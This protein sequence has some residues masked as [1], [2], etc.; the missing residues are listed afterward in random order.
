MAGKGLEDERLTAEREAGPVA[1]AGLEWT[2]EQGA[3]L[4]ACRATRGLSREGLA[5]HFSVGART[6]GRWERGESPSARVRERV[7][8][9]MDESESE[10]EAVVDDGEV[11][12][13]RVETAGGGD[14]CR[15][16]RW[17]VVDRPKLVRNLAL[18]AEGHHRSVRRVL[19][20]LGVGPGKAQG[21][22]IEAAIK[23]LEEPES[24]EARYRRDGWV[25]QLMAWLTAEATCGPTDLVRYPQSQ[26]AM[27][28][29]DGLI[30]NLGDGVADVAGV[31]ICEEKATD[32]PRDIITSKVWP[33]VE[34]YES[35]RRDNE[36]QS[37]VTALLDRLEPDQATALVETIHWK[38]VRRYRVSVTGNDHAPA[39]MFAGFEARAPG[40][41]ERRRGEV[42][43]IGTPIS[44]LRSWMT[45]LCADVVAELRRRGQEAVD[46]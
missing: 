46:V 13:I 12:G 38:R 30:V 14:L 39:Q 2:A 21:S 6:V 35:G 25:F 29:L 36:L 4:R 5:A 31:V 19:H 17:T 11:S 28:G 10:L 9:F 7:L 27:H 1:S 16:L 22:P 43:D 34:D 40:P 41:V 15:G 8:A 23:K 45:V 33:E 20:N 44:D 24:D 18:L 42:L 3:R 26:P 37:E 32:R